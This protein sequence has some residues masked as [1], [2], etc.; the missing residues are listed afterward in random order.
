ML[1][2]SVSLST[3]GCPA[4]RQPRLCSA[5]PAVS[6]PSVQTPPRRCA[7]SLT[8]SFASG[9]K[10]GARA[11]PSEKPRATAPAI[12]PRTAGSPSARAAA[13]VRMGETVNGKLDRSHSGQAMAAAAPSSSAAEPAGRSATIRWMR[14]AVRSQRCAR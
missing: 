9:S 6:S 10:R 7:I 3:A 4:R 11:R 14:L 8:G 5:R 12:A 13:S 1:A 2:A